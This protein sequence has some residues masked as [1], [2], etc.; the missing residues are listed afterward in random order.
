ML[1][2]PRFILGLTFVLAC[3]LLM[4]ADIDPIKVTDDNKLNDSDILAE[5][6]GGT[7]TRKDIDTKISKLPPQYQ[8]RYR[9]VDGQIEVLNIAAVEEA[10]FQKAKQLGLDKDQAVLEKIKAVEKRYYMQEF[11][12]RN[13]SDLVVL[14]DQDLQD[15]YAQNQKVFYLYPYI[16]I[17]YLQVADENEGK[18]ALAE[19]K[20]GVSFAEVSDKYN[21]NTYAKGLKG[22]VKNVR[23]N[24]NIPGIG[25]DAEL[26]GL[27]SKTKVDTLSF[28][29]PVQT[30]TGWHIF[31][32]TEWIEGRQKEFSEVKPEIEQRLRPLKEREALDT[33]IDRLKLKYS[34]EI[35]SSMANVIDL[36]SPKINEGIIDNLVVKSPTES[37]RMTVR[38]IMDNFDKIPPQ[39][40]IFVIKGGGVYQLI[41]QELIQNLL[42]LES[43]ASGYEKYFND[44][45]DYQQTKRSYILRAAYEKLVVNTIEV[46]DQEIADRYER[47]LETYTN[48][49]S[50]TI[51]VLF[52][53]KKK[54][55]DKTWRK[56]NSAWK[57]NNEKKMQEIIKK[58]SLKP[59]NA[60][61]E[62]QYQN[63][64]VTGLGN[65]QE[66]SRMI[67]A[68]PVGYLS[69]VFTSARGDIVFFRILKEIPKSYKPLVEVNPR[70]Y[71]AIKKE[72]EK[73]TQDKVAEDLFVEFNMKKY[74]ERVKLS[75]TADELFT[76]AD[77]AARQRNFKDAIV[78]YDQI[79]NSYK[80]NSDDYK[81][82][83]MKAFLIAEE[84]KQTDLALTLFRE[85]LDKYPEG[86]LHESARFMIDSLEGKIP[87]LPETEE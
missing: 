38:Q 78:Y 20:K 74:P 82:S 68:N 81:A 1:I 53:D 41:D 12:K 45:P 13:V 35:D 63:G 9:T 70:I 28:V 84:M 46:S 11:Y 4:A 27:I 51:E 30:S 47:D 8:P 54:I 85:F 36:N 72:K 6:D 76:Q 86:D 66:F 77:T 39:E 64:I 56:F 59:E 15:Y 3:L 62:N 58:Y 21:Q 26:E 87:E 67:W 5:F 65:D 50:R 16:T 19:L 25:N 29:G 23:L 10:F 60:V 24:G 17:D 73:T 31:R 57:K 71:G 80:N 83:F 2:R 34:V 49:A 14:S 61:L 42:Y 43:K 75:M 55:A 18:K 32:T 22:K 79:I 44:N 52:F 40:Q 69:P 33:L 37:L 48:P 7:I